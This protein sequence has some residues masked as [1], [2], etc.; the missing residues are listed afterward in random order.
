MQIPHF[1]HD[2]EDVL[3]PLWRSYQLLAVED[4]RSTSCIGVYYF[5]SMTDYSRMRRRDEIL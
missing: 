3:L 4:L 2:E 5:G 1:F